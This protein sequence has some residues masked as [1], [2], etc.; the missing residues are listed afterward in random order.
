[1]PKARIE[2]KIAPTMAGQP[3][4]PSLGERICCIAVGLICL[5]A[6][7]AFIRFPEDDILRRMRNAGVLSPDSPAAEPVVGG[8]EP[9]LAGPEHD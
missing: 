3:V 2:I 5:G 9:A 8:P 6:F 1:M 7:A 4:S